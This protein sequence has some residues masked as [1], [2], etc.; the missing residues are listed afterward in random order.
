M[1]PNDVYITANFIPADGTG[2]LK[3]YTVIFETLGGTQIPSVTVSAGSTI[4]QPPT[5]IRE[6]SI[7]GKWVWYNT[8]GDVTADRDWDFNVDTVN[9]NMTLFATYTIINPPTASNT[10]N[11]TYK[12]NYHRT[13]DS[14]FAFDNTKKTNEKLVEPGEPF[15]TGYTFM[16]WT[17]DAVGNISWLFDQYTLSE[18]F[19]V[20][21]NAAQP[22]LTLYAKWLLTSTPE[23][24]SLLYQDEHDDFVVTDDEGNVIGTAVW[25]EES[26]MWVV[27]NEDGIAIG[28]MI[29]DNEL[30]HYVFVQ[31][32]PEIIAQQKILPPALAQ[33]GNQPFDSSVFDFLP[34]GFVPTDAYDQSAM[35]ALPSVS[36]DLPKTG[37][38]GLSVIRLVIL[39]I[40][41]WGFAMSAFCG[42]CKRGAHEK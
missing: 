9:S 37:A 14:D 32:P 42:L 31:F 3:V 2:S 40:S 29:W 21:V 5:P 11:V 41:I 30:G 27:F 34:D 24:S 7:F 16:G 6:G 10:V 4:S 39:C 20:N 18:S 8:I 15:R 25:D 38:A 36:D 22:T 35:G 17:R 26:G 12:N 28:E 1:P 23:G 19:G 13:D 33:P